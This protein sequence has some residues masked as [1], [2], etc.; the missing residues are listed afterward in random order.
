V[1]DSADIDAAFMH[2]VDDEIRGSCNGEL[3]QASM[4]GRWRNLRKALQ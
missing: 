2:T 4:P 3:A 1:H